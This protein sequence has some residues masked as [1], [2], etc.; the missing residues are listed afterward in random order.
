[1][2]MRTFYKHGRSCLFIF[3][4]TLASAGS[5]AQVL[6]AGDIAFTAYNSNSITDEFSFVLLKNIPSGTVIY[7]TDNAWLEAPISAL[8][9][10]EETITWT[11][12]SSLVAGQEIKISGL[13]ATLSAG[14]GTPGTVTGTALNLSTGGDQILA[15]QGSIASPTFIS[16]IHMNVYDTNVGDAINTTAASWDAGNSNNTNGS[17]LPPGLTTATDCIWIGT[18]QVSASEKDNAKFICPGG[19]TTIAQIRAAVNN[20]A[21]WITEDQPANT[22]LPPSGCNFLSVLPIRFVYFDAKLNADKTA[23]LEWNLSQQND[24]KEFVVERSL[25]GVAFTRIGTLA[26]LYTTSNTYSYTDNQVFAGENYYRIR[27]NYYSGKSDYSSVDE[28][29][30]KPDADIVLFPN[31]VTDHFTVRQFGAMKNKWA[32]LSDAFGRTRQIS[33]TS[34][35]QTIDMSGMPAG[36]YILKMEDGTVFKLAKQKN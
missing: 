24:V 31:P 22:I 15:F 5:K 10:G 23:R 36:V 17:A 16:A 7:F 20:Q 28:L 14:A 30:I 9:S 32:V 35:M 27:I 6:S 25:D 11:S 4:L 18:F 12:N 26:A 21:N 1:M 34:S 33:L 13:T 19:Y 29:T 3:I 2:S 8:R